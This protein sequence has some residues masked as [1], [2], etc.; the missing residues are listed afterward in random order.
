MI[1]IM[2]K[3][4][5]VDDGIANMIAAANYDFKDRFGDNADMVKEFVDGWVVK[6]ERNTSRFAPEMVVLLGVLLSTLMMTRNSK[7]VIC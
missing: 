7:K 3:F 4:D 5:N 1:D 6:K 2:K